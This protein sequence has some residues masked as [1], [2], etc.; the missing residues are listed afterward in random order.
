MQIGEA[1]SEVLGS[2]LVKR[3]DLFVTSKLWND[4]H[5]ETA[6]ENSVRK[7]LSDLQLDYLDLYL[8][9]W[10]VT[11][12]EAEVLTPSTQET[13]LAMESLV[14]KGLVKSIGVSNFT[15][16]KLRDMKRYATIFP[17]V[18]QVEVHPLW[19]Q[20]EL[21]Q[22]CKELGSILTMFILTIITNFKNLTVHRCSCHCLFTSW[23]TWR[24]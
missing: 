18:N 10:P 22:A 16:K 3:S 23:F 7:T 17:A 20:T 13:W 12:V 21:I 1:F 14:N 19:R 6:V 9:H 8:I 15:E 5:A 24:S 4:S 11:G 2:G